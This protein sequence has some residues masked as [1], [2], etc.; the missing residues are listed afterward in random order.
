[1]VG[2]LTNFRRK[3]S[4]PLLETVH[5]SR[6]GRLNPSRPRPRNAAMTSR[7]K[8]DRINDP[9]GCAPVSEPS[10]VVRHH[11]RPA[12]VFCLASLQVPGEKAGRVVARELRNTG[13]PAHVGVQRLLLGPEGVEQL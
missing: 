10:T 8:G 7:V 9:A 13:V 2:P 1:M 5:S 3:V 12:H 6:T 11:P 4:C